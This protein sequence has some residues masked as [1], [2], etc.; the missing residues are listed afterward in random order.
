MGFNV[1]VTT[2]VATKQRGIG[3]RLVCVVYER[4]FPKE[5]QS[6]VPRVSKVISS[7][8]QLLGD[9]GSIVGVGEVDTNFTCGI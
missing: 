7:M 6:F 1:V 8:V 5:N 4:L 3:E 9:D 2:T